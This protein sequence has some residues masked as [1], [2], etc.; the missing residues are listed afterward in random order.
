M[1]HAMK[2]IRSGIC[3]AEMDAASLKVLDA[4]IAMAELTDTETYSVDYLVIEPGSKEVTIVHNRTDEFLFVVAGKVTGRVGGTAVSLPPGGYVEIPRGTPHT[5]T[6][7][8]PETCRLVSFCVPKY[9]HED[10]HKVDPVG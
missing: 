5:F 10:V 8:G 4:G 3:S 6:N 2:S 9:S 1:Q 7:E